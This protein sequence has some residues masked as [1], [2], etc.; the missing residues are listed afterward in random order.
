ML[1]PALLSSLWLPVR[2]GVGRAGDAVARHPDVPHGGRAGA[3]RRRSGRRPRGDDRHPAVPAERG[4]GGR[5][6]AGGAHDQRLRAG[7]ARRR[8]RVDGDLPGPPRLRR[9]DLHGAG[10]RGVVGLR[11]AAEPHLRRQGRPAADH[12]GAR[13]AAG[14]GEGRDRRGRR[15]GRRQ[16]R[17]RDPGEPRRGR[18]ARSG[19]SSRAAPGARCSTPWTPT[20]RWSPATRPASPR[21]S[22]PRAC[23][24]SSGR[25]CSS[26]PATATRRWARAAARRTS[27]PAATR[28]P[29]AGLPCPGFYVAVCRT[30]AGISATGDSTEADR[31]LLADSSGTTQLDRLRVPTLLVQGQRD[32][33]FTLNDAVSTY[34][35]L[36]RRGVPVKMI[37]N[38]GG[39]GGY[40]SRPG[41]CEVYGGGTGG[42]ADGFRGLDDCYLTLR[43]L[44]FLDAHLRGRPDP[45]PG[46]T[47]YQDWTPYGGSGAADE[48]YGSAAAFP[49]MP[50]THLHAVRRRTPWSPPARPPGRRPS[51]TRRA[52]CRRPTARPRTRAGP[53]SSPRVDLPPTEQPGQSVAFTSAPFP[54]GLVSVGVPRG[55]PAAVAR[56]P[57]RPRPVRQGLRRRPRRQRRAAPP[58]DLA[59]AGAE[60]RPR[61]RR[62]G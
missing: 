2:A 53:R 30:F 38:W 36:Q 23:S 56:L 45:S 24:S 40:D 39:H 34:T 44:A 10:V 16:L 1:V 58:A 26:P 33:L 5:P 60:R 48:Q 28:P 15:D 32:T 61:P 4:D 18:R 12:E 62:C 19:R 13:A 52:G 11:D 25:R 59:R 7:Q 8:D 43:T 3:R 29:T 9:P 49:A 31:A 17:R 6:A 14:G 47:W 51:P 27:S 21:P 42:R 35:A 20:T 22:T 57:G 41:E 50:S 54:T 55:G 37:W 46:F